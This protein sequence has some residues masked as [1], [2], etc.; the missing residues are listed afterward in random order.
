MVFGWG[1]KKT[2]NKTIEPTK[3]ERQ[4]SLSEVNKLLEEIKAPRLLRILQEAKSIREQVELER[5]SITDT[6]LHLEKDDLKIN[7]VDKSIR[8]QIKRSKDS[9]ISSIKREI[10]VKLS[11]PENYT[12]IESLNVELSQL[13]K[14]IGD[15]LGVNSRIMHAFAR[16]YADRLKED[17]AK[18]AANKRK[19]QQIVD[20]HTNYE[21]SILNI[22]EGSD[23]I[24]NLSDK[25]ENKNRELIQFNNQI[26]NYKKT[27]EGLEY[28][29]Q[30]LKSKTVYRE[31][32]NIKKEIE[33]LTPERNTIKNEISMQFSKISRPLGKYSYISAFDKPLKKIMEGLISDP[34]D[35]ITQ[36]NRSSIIVVL[37]AVIKS[38][39]AGNVSVK[40]SGRAVQLIEET[41]FKLDEF[42]SQK[43]AYDKKL[44]NLEKKCAAFDIRE[45]EEKEKEIARIRENVIHLESSVKVLENGNKE[46]SK[47]IPN[48]VADIEAKLNKISGSKLALKV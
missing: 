10:S 31:F 48:L 38:V 16:K 42:L 4:I 32:L 35:V 27:I 28:E 6:I 24:K 33:L 19:L 29:N 43:D 40:D 44:A 2:T 14:R 8:S 17:L 12:G 21:S 46:D 30:N 23:K 22:M 45:F 3:L 39:V 7:D 20:E 34:S 15:I 37:Q 25:I 26:Q 18:V 9:V 5:K 47:L 11:D 41:I 1:K 13:L 36:E